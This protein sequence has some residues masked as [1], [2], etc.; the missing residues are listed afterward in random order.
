MSNHTGAI[1]NNPVEVDYVFDALFIEE[2]Y[3]FTLPEWTIK[4]KKVYPEPMKF[5]RDLSFQ[6]TTWN[7][8]LKRLKSGPLIQDMLDR[9]KRIAKEKNSSS[10]VDE[11]KKLEPKM[12]MYSAHDTT[13]ARHFKADVISADSRQFY[14]EMCIGTAK[15]VGDEQGGV[16][17]HFVDFLSVKE[18]YSVGDY[19]RDVDLF[20]KDYFKKNDIAVLVGGAG[21]FIDAV[22]QGLD[23]FPE[24]DGQIRNLLNAQFAEEGVSPLLEKLKEIDSSYYEVVDKSNHRRIIRALEVCISSGKPFSSFLT[25]NSKKDKYPVIRIGLKMDRELLNEQIE[26]GGHPGVFRFY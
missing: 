3:N 23:E 18:P 24:T 11:V 9:A 15:P 1:I 25:S 17:H 12:T 14:K 5:L 21:L 22:C 4:P 8:E 7:H 26:P 10:L 6:L 19:E 2:V 13:L 16:S 20:L